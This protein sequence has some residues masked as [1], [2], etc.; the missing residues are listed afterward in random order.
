[1]HVRVAGQQHQWLRGGSV[2]ARPHL[3]TRRD[4]QG[5]AR[6]HAPAPHLLQLHAC[7]Q[8]S[9]Y[10]PHGAG[11]CDRVEA[12]AVPPQHLAADGLR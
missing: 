1:M 10:E 3:R 5:G 8:H 4:K 6:G 12:H 7:V 9:L 11:L 2:P